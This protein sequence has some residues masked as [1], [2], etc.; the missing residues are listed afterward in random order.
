M[1]HLLL[2]KNQYLCIILTLR[3]M[4]RIYFDNPYCSASKF[5]EDNKQLLASQ[6]SCINMSID[7]EDGDIILFLDDNF[8]LPSS[9][10]VNNGRLKSSS[11][12]VTGYCKNVPVTLPAC[13]IYEDD[14]INELS[15][16]NEYDALCRVKKFFG[17]AW[18]VRRAKVTPKDWVLNVELLF[19]S[20]VA[21]T[22]TAQWELAKHKIQM[23]IE[24]DIC[25]TEIMS[26]YEQEVKLRRKQIEDRY[27][28]ERKANTR[29]E[30]IELESNEYHHTT[31]RF[32]WGEGYQEKDIYEVTTKYLE[33]TY[34]KD[35]LLSERKVI[36]TQSETY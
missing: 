10:Q 23:N 22:D 34:Y 28:E 18:K 11:Y 8:T 15:F 7:V 25:R 17:R 30:L 13:C 4:E 3:D 12:T 32:T 2:K 27:E 21:D 36:K 9:Y 26:R 35:S 14:N 1:K 33:R 16:T 20:P 31:S 24:I 19:L 5:I 29:I 6:E